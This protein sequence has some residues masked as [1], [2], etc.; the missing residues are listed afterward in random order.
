MTTGDD[1]F[2]SRWSRRKRA[3]EAEEAASEPA[4]PEASEQLA[5]A[6]EDETEEQTLE[7]LGLPDP[8]SLSEGDDFTGFLKSGVPDA[9]RRRAL[10]RLWR[11][12]PVL[13]NVDG[14]VD[15]GDDFTD[16]AMVPDV[17][18][19]AYKV[20][21]GML[22]KIT[23]DDDVEATAD[24]VKTP[25]GL[26]ETDVESV[27]VEDDVSTT[28]DVDNAD[29]VDSLEIAEVPENIG[30]AD[31]DDSEVAVWRPRRMRFTNT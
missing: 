26:D 17:L 7:R 14:L 3:V 10:R 2:L 1:D 30:N 24:S 31:A 19:T 6:P 27:A 29:E 13:A 11:S 9:L 28:A 16:A 8:D 15:Y 20:G 12:N 23:E 25:S 4:V 21:Q 22:K 5:P 18:A